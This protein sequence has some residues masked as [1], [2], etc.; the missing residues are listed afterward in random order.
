MGT[1]IPPLPDPDKVPA[2]DQCSIC[3]GVGKTFGNVDTPS[4]V[5]ASVSGIEHGPSWIPSDGE[6][7]EGKFE[8]VQHDTKSCWFWYYQEPYGIGW[9][10]EVLNSEVYIFNVNGPSHFDSFE[11]TCSLVYNNQHVTR[12]KNGSVVITLPETEIL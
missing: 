3:W 10:N 2:G 8:L 11:T 6:P 7:L 5:I 4:K 9:Y 12:F 1:P